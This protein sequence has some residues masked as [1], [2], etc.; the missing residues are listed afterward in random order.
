MIPL[1]QCVNA[2][3]HPATIFF[4]VIS[5]STLEW[6]LFLVSLLAVIAYPENQFRLMETGRDPGVG[7][8]YAFAVMSP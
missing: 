4:V 5:A 1:R 2:D 3:R 8:G 6:A 7:V